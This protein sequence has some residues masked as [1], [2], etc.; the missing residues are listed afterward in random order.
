MLSKEMHH[1][2]LELSVW[3]N[4]RQQSKDSSRLLTWQTMNTFTQIK[5]IKAGI[6]IPPSSDMVQPHPAHANHE[7]CTPVRLVT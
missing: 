5:H 4:L 3:F 6:R 7:W 2:E 1:Y